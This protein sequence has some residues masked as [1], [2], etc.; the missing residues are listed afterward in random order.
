MG[1]NKPVDEKKK[2]KL[3][4][5]GQGTKEIRTLAKK[6]K[7]GQ[8]RGNLKRR[9]DLTGDEEE[10]LLQQRRRSTKF[11]TRFQRMR[12]SDRATL[13]QKKPKKERKRM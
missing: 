9:S 12:I 5:S 11:C 13:S 8:S 7:E 10:S 3:H 2:R 1:G 4:V 6:K